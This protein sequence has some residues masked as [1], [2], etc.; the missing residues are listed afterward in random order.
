MRTLVG[1]IALASVLCGGCGSE[2]RVGKWCGRIWDASCAKLVECHAV[3]E[4]VPV[5]PMDCQQ[6]RADFQATCAMGPGAGAISVYEDHQVNACVLEIGMLAC[7]NVCNQVPE[8]PSSCAAYGTFPLT[9][10]V[11]CQ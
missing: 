10:M 5:T 7:A 4:G 3:M 8:Y 9:D 2:D 11:S 1:W 6:S